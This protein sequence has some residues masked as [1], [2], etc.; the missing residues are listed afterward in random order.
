MISAILLAAALAT[1]DAPAPALDVTVEDVTDLQGTWEVVEA[2]KD[3][4]EV[5]KYLKGARLTI[6]GDT[7]KNANGETTCQIKAGA[8]RLDCLHE[9][10]RVCPG[11]YRLDGDT[12]VWTTQQTT[13]RFTFRRVPH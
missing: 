6:A 10:G 8:T 3:G 9:N 4:K 13:L 2:E 12:L 1:R 7:L 11:I 5:S